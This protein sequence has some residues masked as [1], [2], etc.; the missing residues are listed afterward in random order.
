MTDRS[1]GGPWTQEK[2]QILSRYLNE[3][4]TALKNRPFR[5]IYVDAFA[6]EGTW[7]PGSEYSN[8]Y[9]DFREFFKGSAR[10]ALEIQ[11]KQFDRLIFVEKGPRALSVS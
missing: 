11:D 4:T 5:L 9:D 10:I 8:D 3:Y 6:G 1:F 2:L 7:R